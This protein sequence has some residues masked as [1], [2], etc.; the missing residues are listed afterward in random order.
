MLSS[1]K[2][3]LNISIQK[4]LIIL[5]TIILSILLLFHSNSYNNYYTSKI[6]I[7]IYDDQKDIGEKIRQELNKINNEKIKFFYEKGGES[8]NDHEFYRWSYKRN[9]IKIV[10]LGM[11]QKLAPTRDK[12]GLEDLKSSKLHEEFINKILINADKNTNKNYKI[13]KNIYKNIKNKH[14]VA[15]V[16][17]IGSVNTKIN[18]LA[19]EAIKNYYFKQSSKVSA[20]CADDRRI[21]L[22][23]NE[24]LFINTSF[25]LNDYEKF[26]TTPPRITIEYVNLLGKKNNKKNIYIMVIF[27]LF[28][29]LLPIFLSKN[30]D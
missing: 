19:V 8:R 20:N 11:H 27:F 25:T 15:L 12:I 26:C 24:S 17:H 4:K 3:F 21:I 28:L 10:S 2:I 9:A 23:S 1:L 13:F 16:V 30:Y 18:E 5:L 6:N 22:S 7:Y 29:V 14:A